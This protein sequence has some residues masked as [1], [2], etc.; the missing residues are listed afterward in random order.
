V[1]QARRLGWFQIVIGAF[2]V[3]LMGVITFVVSRVISES[4]RPGAGARFTGSH[5]DLM[6]MYGIFGVVIAIGLMSIVGGVMTI[7]YGRTNK[8]VMF[9]IIALAIAFYILAMAFNRSSG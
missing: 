6:F 9:L 1:R 2:L 5:S 3:A 4:G 8:V 7:R